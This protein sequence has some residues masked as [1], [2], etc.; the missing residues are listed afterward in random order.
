MKTFKQFIK[1]NSSSSK[2]D[3]SKVR[4]TMSNVT[5][6]YTTEKGS[7]YAHGSD[8]TSIRYKAPRLEKGKMK[9][10]KLEPKSSRTVFMEPEHAKRMAEVY[11]SQGQKPQFVPHPNKPGHAA[12][13]RGVDY[14]PHKAGSII[15]GG[16]APYST[17]PKVGLSPV[18]HIPVGDGRYHA[19][20]GHSI[21]HVEKLEK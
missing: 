5:H 16:E 10:G 21:V 8:N 18:E 19:H 3:Y 4:G 15:H 9:G 14:G 12:I 6:H 13:V 1:E 7:T 17:T 11:Q 20:F 2:P